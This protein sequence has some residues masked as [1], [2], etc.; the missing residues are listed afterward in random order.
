VKK[1]ES[2]KGDAFKKIMEQMAN[3]YNTLN[4]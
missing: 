1:V 3:S 2:A 4:T